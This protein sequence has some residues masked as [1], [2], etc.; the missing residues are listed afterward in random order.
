MKILVAGDAPYIHT[1]RWLAQFR[2][3]GHEVHVASF[4]ASTLPGVKV[5]YLRTFGLGKPA[6]LLHLPT[7]RLL[8][9]R[10]RPDVVHAHYVTSY[11][12][13]SSLA[14]LR[15]LVCTVWGSDVL[16]AP[17]QS[18][19][20]RFAA[21]Y[22]LMHSNMITVTAAHM[23]KATYALN[24]G[25]PEIHV[26]P[27]GVDTSVF[28]LAERE[29]GVSGRI[30]LICTR[31]FKPIYD[32]HTFI[33]AMALL[34]KA[35]P[36]IM[37]TLIGEGPLQT[38]L[39]ALAKTLGV[40]D[41]VRFMG[42]V[43]STKVAACL[44]ESEIFV[45]PSLSDSNNVSLTEAMA[46]GCFPIGSDIPASREWIVD[47]ENGYLFP[48]G[49][50]EALAEVL[51]QAIADSALRQSARQKNRYIVETKANWQSSVQRTYDLFDRLLS[52]RART[53]ASAS[54]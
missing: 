40:D 47:G 30:R 45:T 13:I 51:K 20:L 41:V 48:P 35:I 2:D 17:R 53:V 25:T 31:N 49:N 28:K 21:R 19:L 33:R 9:R 16:I 6:Y 26:I 15:P 37:A 52:P 39:I 22:A 42:H 11:G 3:D 43:D 14:G 18:S 50:A 24:I 12:F 38:E 29:G 32:V 1:Q 27:F 23:K 8:A 54:A 36:S 34:R 5:H 10:L 7:M 4:R 46:C 44:A